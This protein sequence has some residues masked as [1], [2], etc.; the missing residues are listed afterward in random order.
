MRTYLHFSGESLFAAR[1]Y[2]S[3]G[4]ARIELVEICMHEKGVHCN[5]I[6]VISLTARAV[7]MPACVLVVCGFL[8]CQQTESLHDFNSS[9]VLRPVS[10]DACKVYH[11][12]FA[13]CTTIKNLPPLLSFL[14][15]VFFIRL[16]TLLFSSL[17]G[18]ARPVSMDMKN[19]FDKYA[20]EA[21]VS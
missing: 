11:V 7:F 1:M 16:S 4:C 14:L 5:G 18:H 6:Q 19:I 8:H 13:F 9:L 10:T 20:P 3:Q 2:A 21:E 15:L 17:H 12:P